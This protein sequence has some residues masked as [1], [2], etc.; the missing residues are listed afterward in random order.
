MQHR[1]AVRT[2][3]TRITLLDF[4]SLSFIIVEKCLLVQ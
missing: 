4:V 1:R 2:N 3:E